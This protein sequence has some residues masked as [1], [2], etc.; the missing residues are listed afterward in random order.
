MSA[1]GLHVFIRIT[2][3][4]QLGAEL[5]VGLDEE[6]GPADTDPEHRRLLGEVGLQLGVH[7]LI[8]LLVRRALLG[9]RADGGG[10]HAGVVEHVRVVQG[11]VERVET[12]HGQTADGA[13]LLLRDG[14][15]VIPLSTF[16]FLN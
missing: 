4:V 15:V 9:A 5:V 13:A 7:V 16:D 11:D 2:G 6:I 8:D 12:A 14:A 10:E 3:G 1:L